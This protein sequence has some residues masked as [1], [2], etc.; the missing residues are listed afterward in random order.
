MTR[1][2]IVSVP[3]LDGALQRTV[4]NVD[5][6]TSSSIRGLMGSQLSTFLRA[7]GIEG[8]EIGVRPMERAGMDPRFTGDWHGELALAE[9]LVELAG[10]AVVV[11]LSGVCN[12]KAS[13]GELPMRGRLKR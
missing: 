5:A 8:V 7:A 6:L 1:K 9:L 3:E 11:F 2:V 4:R 12:R 10:D 13:A